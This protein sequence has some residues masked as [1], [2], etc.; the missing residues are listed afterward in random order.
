MTAADSSEHGG[1]IALVEFLSVSLLLLLLMLL[2]VAVFVTARENHDEKARLEM[3]FGTPGLID[4]LGLGRG[5]GA[6]N[7]LRGKI[8]LR[9][10]TQ[11]SG[12]S[13]SVDL[14]GRHGAT[15][16]TADAANRPAA[17]VAHRVCASGNNGAG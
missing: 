15:V 9:A 2:F 11:D 8:P 16:G 1:R 4:G 3:E 6:F 7:L 14:R 13:L 12:S 5:L 17:T 10:G